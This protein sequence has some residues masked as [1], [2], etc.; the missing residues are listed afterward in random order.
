MAQSAQNVRQLVYRYVV[1]FLATLFVVS[2][3]TST[4]VAEVPVEGFIPLVGFGLTDQFSDSGGGNPL[5]FVSEARDGVGG[6]LLGHDGAPYYDVA[7]LDTGAAT[8]ILRYDASGPDGFDIAGNGFSGTNV[9][10]I[11]GATGIVDLWINDPH[12]IYMAGLGDRASAGPD[13]LE[14]APSFMRGEISFAT[15]SAMDE[16]WELPNVIG[17]PMAA[18]HGVHIKNSEPQIFSLNGRTARTPQIDLRTLGSGGQ[19]IVRRAQLDLK[20]GENFATGPLYVFD[21]NGILNGDPLHENPASPSVI[22][23]S[24]FYLDVDMIDGTNNIQGSSFLFDTGA[25]LTV[26]STQTALLL[27]IDPILDTPEFT[28]AVEGSGGVTAGIPG[29]YLDELSLLTAGGTFVKQD[30]PVAILDVTDPSNIGNTVPGI[31]G[32][33]V[34]SDRDLM[35]DANPSLGGGGAP[36]SLYIS[37]P[38]TN[39]CNW[40]STAASQTW[41]VGANW[42]T[43]LPTDV[44]CDAVIANV[45]GTNQQAVISSGNTSTVYRATISGS[46]NAEMA[47]VVQGGLLAYADVVVK[48]DGRLHLDSSVSTAKVDAQFIEVQDGALTGSGEIFVG[49]G[50]IEGTVRNVAGLVAPGDAN[51]NPIGTLAITGDFG[52]QGVM[53]FDLGG[54]ASSEFDSIS[55]SRNMYLEGTLDVNLVA[56][57]GG[58]IFTPVNGD[59]FE[60]LTAD[61]DIVGEFDNLMLPTLPGNFIWNVNY[62]GSAVVLEVTTA[63]GLICDADGDGDCDVLDI[64]AMYAAFGSNTQLFDY[65]VSGI[66]DQND[67]PGWLAAASDPAN[68]AKPTSADVFVIGDV[69]LNGNVDSLDLGIL[70]NNFND[71]SSLG[72]G[73]GNLNGDAVVDSLDLGQLLNEFNFTS[74]ASAAVPEPGSIVLLLMGLS[75]FVR[76]ARS[77]D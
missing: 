7:L 45:S 52:N 58:V 36:P 56:L 67:I 2:Q 30:V 8:H 27:G 76:F 47:A 61:S 63:G 64:D 28:L 4:A 38:I 25:S 16:G 73:G 19:G 69:D 15:L 46:P 66:V 60:I 42:S 62:T 77:R 34:F 23:N 50:P 41:D 51:G 5:F 21:T 39:A 49:A 71:A 12:G 13:G 10:A 68:P 33:N 1:G 55:A 35:I 32:M 20:T 70:L 3:M 40:T 24:A 65:D 22:P 9:Q 17:M 43:N 26:L 29:Y 75:V 59:T 18:H 44:M 48:K 74:A 11:G 14:M 72:W 31:L 54:T 53:E 6:T 57:P 37:D